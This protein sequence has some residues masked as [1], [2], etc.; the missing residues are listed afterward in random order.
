[1]AKVYKN[2]KL[3][4]YIQGFARSLLASKS[5]EKKINELYKTLSR[6]EKEIV[7]N[8]VNYYNKI[9]TPTT[10][11]HQGTRI[12]DL[13]KPKTPKAY[14]FDTYEFARYFPDHFF[15][16]F[17]FGD[18]NTI[19]DFPMITKSRPIHGNNENNIL[20]NLDKTRHFVSVKDNIDFQEK[21]DLLIGRAAVYQQ[22]RITFYEK[23]FGN[24][25]CD[26][27]QV[28]RKGGNPRWIKPKISVSEHLRHKFILSLEGNDVATNLK[29]IMSSNSIAVSPP[30]KM[31][32]W[33]ME[34]ILKP[35]EHF[36]GIK[37]NYEDLED[38]IQY[39]L[40][41]PKEA[42][43]IIANAKRHRAQFHNK[44]VENLVSILVLKKYFEYIR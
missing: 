2:N 16:D 34:G 36:I 25:L 41:H 6:K 15:I 31:E 17:E 22:H 13:K 27:G 33:Y 30:L 21:K 3:F 37:E 32:S 29:W 35:D 4:L 42:K 5:A 7:E 12:R 20:L 18:V 9:Q 40:D 14:Y 23:Y 43:D 8:R 19:L 11:S 24:S 39:Y 38:K 10:V 44:S 1:M 28:N 26:L